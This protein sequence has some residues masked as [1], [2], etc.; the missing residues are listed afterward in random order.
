MFITSPGNHIQTVIQGKPLAAK[1]KDI[2]I[3]SAQKKEAGIKI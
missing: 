3:V 2:I 1:Y